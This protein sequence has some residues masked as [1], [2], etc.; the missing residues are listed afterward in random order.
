MKKILI[1]SF[2]LVALPAI[3]STTPYLGIG[4]GYH[5]LS[6]DIKV[7]SL[8]ISDV[9]ANGVASVLMLGAR[10]NISDDYFLST[11]VNYLMSD[12]DFS[13]SVNG[14]TEKIEIDRSYGLSIHLGKRFSNDDINIYAKLG[15]QKDKFTYVNES[16]NY[17]SFR[18]G[19]GS[20]FSVDEKLKLGIEWT[21]A[22]Y[23]KK[24]DI[25]PFGTLFL[26]TASYNF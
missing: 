12:A 1:T 11:E 26:V 16:I 18:F 10:K 23:Q 7:D 22:Q 15:Y 2:A 20:Q 3:S 17:N 24:E 8:S 19:L 4:L 13:V 5:Q 21:A 14:T 25:K 6:T 9:A